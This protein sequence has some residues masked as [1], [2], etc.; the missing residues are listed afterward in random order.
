MA[1]IAN[2]SSQLGA[3]SIQYEAVS[4]ALDERARQ[5]ASLTQRS[6]A[7]TE[8]AEQQVGKLSSALKLGREDLDAHR[9]ELARAKDE[10]ATLEQRLAAMVSELATVQTRSAAIE[11]ERAALERRV[12]LT[13][14]LVDSIR[15]ERRRGRS[16]R[17]WR[18]WRLS[19]GNH[20]LGHVDMRACGI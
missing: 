5:V 20:L 15:E 6:A 3:A 2:L 11:S 18:R 1:E 4:G 7:L 8:E 12:A 13:D 19:C 9:T 17:L 10:R 16:G 14:R